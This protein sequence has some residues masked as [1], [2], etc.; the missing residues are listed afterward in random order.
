MEVTFL[1]VTFHLQTMAIFIFFVQFIYLHI[2]FTFG[3]LHWFMVK[4]IKLRLHIMRY[5]DIW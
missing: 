1:Q 2:D 3:L 5:F 4:G